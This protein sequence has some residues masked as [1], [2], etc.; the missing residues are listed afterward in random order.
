MRGERGA[1]SALWLALAHRPARWVKGGGR[2]DLRGGLGPRF[3][4]EGWG[5]RGV[6]R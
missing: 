6:L 5:M 3:G 4:Q 2:E 1:C